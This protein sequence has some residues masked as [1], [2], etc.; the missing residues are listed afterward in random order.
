MALTALLSGPFALLAAM[1]ENTMAG[2]AAVLLL[3]AVAPAIEETVKI[4]GA[5]YVAEQRPWLVP[6]ALVLPVVGLVS[7]LV[8]ATVENWWYLTVLVPD[9]PRDLVA[10]RWVFG[11]L[12]H[13]TGSFTAGIGVAVMWRRARESGHRP[14]FS[15]AQPWLVAAVV[16][17]GA[18][19]VFAVLLEFAGR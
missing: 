15:D 13:G 9:P 8:F 3:A 12:V 19:N 11:P 4:A 6:T 7:G 2:V 10:W 1:Y 17:H 18:Y 5:A 16:W 14:S